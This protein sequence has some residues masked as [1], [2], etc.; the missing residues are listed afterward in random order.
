M[1]RRLSWT[2]KV[3]ILDE[4]VAKRFMMAEG[5]GEEKRKDLTAKIDAL[6]ERVDTL[7]N[8]MATQ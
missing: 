5:L 8:S 2:N 4:Q 7:T 3:I 1:G 6:M